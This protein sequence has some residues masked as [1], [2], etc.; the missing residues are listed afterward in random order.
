MRVPGGRHDTARGA[1]APRVPAAPAG[2]SAPDRLAAGGAPAEPSRARR[3]AAAD[4]SEIAGLVVEATV[5]RFADAAGVYILEE[6]LTPG[7]HGGPDTPRQDGGKLIA[8]RLGVGFGQGDRQV[9]DDA[10]PDG[11]VVAFGNDAPTS[12]CVAGGAPVLFG[13]PESRALA[14][15]AHRRGSTAVVASLRSLLAVPMAA[16]GTI[17]GVLVFARTPSAACF[18]DADAAA[19]AGLAARAGA[20]IADALQLTRQRTAAEALQRVL[21]ARDPAAPPG[22]EVEGRCL[23]AAGHV[24]GGDWYDIISLPGPKTGLVIG[25]VMDH[26]PEA[27]AL[28]AQLRAAAHALAD[29]DLEPAELLRRLDRTAHTL[30]TLSYATCTYAVLDAVHGSCVIASAGPLPPVVALPGGATRVPRPPSGLPLGLGV[31][32]Y[33]QARIT[34]PPGAVLA[35]YTDGLVESRQRTSDVGILAL[36]SALSRQRGSLT[37]AC[38]TLIGSLAGGREDDTTLVLAR[39]PSGEPRPVPTPATL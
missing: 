28:M 8:R 36:R 4:L 30:R 35:L 22:I 3:R 39:I 37:D 18:E 32:I 23:P 15:A 13:R 6:L 34:L 17:I 25:D 31:A 11:E 38:D 27:A 9:P 1:A 33:G 26:G 16:H 19:V 20:C 29:L 21:T 5:P 24:V 12:R 14:Q 10:F 2:P 7:A